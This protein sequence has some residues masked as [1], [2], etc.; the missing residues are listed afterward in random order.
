LKRHLQS[1]PKASHPIRRNAHSPREE[2]A[3]P[4]FPRKDTAVCKILL[5]S[6]TPDRSILIGNPS[7]FDLIA[8]ALRT[9]TLRV[10]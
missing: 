2:S 6:P 3:G 5:G 4:K 7:H 8:H 9:S 10:A 1:A